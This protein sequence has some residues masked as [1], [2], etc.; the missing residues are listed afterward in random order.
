MEHHL[1]FKKASHEN[2]WVR[3]DEKLKYERKALC[4]LTVLGTNAT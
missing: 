1:G 3:K 4:T 2:G